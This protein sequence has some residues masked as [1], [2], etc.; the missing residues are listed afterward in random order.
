MTRLNQ[1]LAGVFV[2]Q[3]AIAI[4]IDIVSRPPSANASAT[5]VLTV[6]QDRINRI[7]LDDGK[8]DRVT[9]NKVDDRWQ[10]P[11]YYQLPASRTQVENILNTLAT[12]R[13]GWP[14][15]TT[16][17]GI[18]RF[19]VA[20][21]H[22]Q[23]RIT[24]AHD[25]KTLETLFLGDSPG[26][27]QLHLRRSGED[28]VYTVK[29]NSYDFPLKSKNWLDRTLLQPGND[30]AELHGP[31]FTVDKK[32]DG[33]TLA[34]GN[35]EVQKAEISKLVNAITHLTV[36]SA[37]D[38]VD[39]GNA[40]ALTVRAADDSLQYHFFS[41]GSDYYVKRDDYSQPFRIT[42]DVYKKI[43]G[44]TATQLVKHAGDRENNKQHASY[45]MKGGVPT[46]QHG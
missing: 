41:N 37:A 21:D 26:F 19:E 14:V 44:E 4:G 25:D 10:L 35:G 9:L 3:L 32:D 38:K 33:W 12:T 29:L 27:R 11:D 40:Y 31:G 1:I 24:L 22:Y 5:S 36:E 13:S 18:E 7:V 23:T 20:D 2:L 15:A 16:S 39:A 34:N 8:S 46:K 28:K 6:Q 43:T 45:N 17:S 30:I 42:K